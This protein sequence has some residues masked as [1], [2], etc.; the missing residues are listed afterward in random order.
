MTKI[1]SILVAVTGGAALV[2]AFL[3]QHQIREAAAARQIAEAAQLEAKNVTAA[4]LAS[5]RQMKAEIDDAKVQVVGF[6]AALARAEQA[7][8]SRPV[9]VARGSTG[10]VA[11][12]AHPGVA[13]PG[14]A[15][16]ALACVLHEGDQGSIDVATAELKT[17]TG[18][19][20][21]VQAAEASRVNPDGS[22]LRLFGGEI[23]ADLT[24]YLSSEVKPAGRSLG[25]G[26]GALALCTASGCSYGVIAG[27]PPLF[28]NRLE[29]SGGAFAGR[30]GTG[31][32]AQV[33]FRFP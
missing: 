7:A 29:L 2:L 1:L 8:K 4:K 27:A 33:M 26:A 21:L 20:V 28:G 18:N 13:P 23:R 31:L 10:S 30:G 3:L 32:Q 22:K 25:L 17:Q 24:K 14:G 9:S 19:R 5:E 12:E 11:V 16:A 15:P 6:A